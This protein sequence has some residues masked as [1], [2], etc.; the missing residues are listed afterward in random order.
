MGLADANKA[1]PHGAEEITAVKAQ[2]KTLLESI[3]SLKTATRDAAT[4]AEEEAVTKLIAEVKTA[5]TAKNYALAK[6]KVK[7][8]QA[9]VDKLKTKTVSK[10]F[11]TKATAEIDAINKELDKQLA[12]ANKAKPSAAEEITAVKAQAKTLLESINSL[13]TTT[14]DAATKAEEKQ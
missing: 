10:D 6:D 2:V 12:D 3:N 1:K 5:V 14:R 11:K 4:K 9:A 13:K 7:A 8:A